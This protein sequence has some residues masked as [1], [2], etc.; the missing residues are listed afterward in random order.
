MVLSSPRYRTTV[1]VIAHAVPGDVGGLG[2][3]VSRRRLQDRSDV[4]R[5]IATAANHTQNVQLATG[6]V[7]NGRADSDETN[8]SPRP[9]VD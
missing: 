7:L 4:R 9:V 2:D 1:D 8:H 6:E 5:V 3:Q